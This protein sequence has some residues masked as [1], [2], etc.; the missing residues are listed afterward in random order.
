MFFCEVVADP[1]TKS[2]FF[3]YGYIQK[4]YRM[5]KSQKMILSAASLQHDSWELARRLHAHTPQ[6]D[7]VVGVARGGMAIALYV[8]EALLILQGAAPEFALVHAKSYSAPGEA[9]GVSIRDVNSL[10]P[11][12]PEDGCAVLIDDIFDRGETLQAVRNAVCPLAPSI[13]WLTATIYS[14]PDAH[15]VDWTPDISLHSLPGDQW[16]I[17]P[18]ELDGLNAEELRAKGFASS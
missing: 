9:G 2:A 1:S 17:F 4:E 15:T 3:L 7:L 13:R 6:I 11:L 12:L 16:L 10:L 14:K 8:H 5:D 18:H